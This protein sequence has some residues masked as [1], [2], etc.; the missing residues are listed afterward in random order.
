MN[1][2]GQH[3]FIVDDNAK[4]IQVTAQILKEHGGEISFAQDG[5]TA[6][7][8]LEKF[9]PD[10]ILLDIK[11]PE[12]S[13]FEVCRQIQGK[14]EIRDIPVIFLTALTEQEFIAQ[15]FEVG[16]VDYITKPINKLEVLAR[17]GNH[18]NLVRSRNEL[19]ELNE[20]LST[21][22]R[23]LSEKN[24][25]LHHLYQQV[26]KQYNDIQSSINYASGIINQLLP[27][28]DEMK[29][30]LKDCFVFFQPCHTI[31]GD[32]YWA[33]QVRDN[34]YFAVVDGTGHGV[35]GALI[36]LHGMVSLNELLVNIEDISTP[37]IVSQLGQKI[38]QSFG[39]L[40]SDENRYEID[41]G[42]GKL[43]T[44]EKKI[45]Y[46]GVNFPL[47]VCRS[48]ETEIFKPNRI[49]LNYNIKNNIPFKCYEIQLKTG[50]LVYL[51]TDGYIDQIGGK[52]NKKLKRRRFLR[53]ITEYHTKDMKEQKTAFK[54][55]IEE[56]KGN[57]IQTDDITL[58][59][60]KV[61]EKY[62]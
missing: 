31:G 61:P 6:L 25:T 24:E 37:E 40:N 30:A 33:T 23:D 11:M 8:Q 32:F 44:T 45:W 55:F 20:K 57:N 14:P 12:M 49:S 43:N 34:I 17:V 46:S 41:L 18:L 48:N 60:L 15:G 35:P 38:M 3:I 27:G 62:P 47:F 52:K 39:E 2:S 36:S 16:G 4:N 56:W 50:D 53:L 59:G 19:K 22:N 10:L 29:K 13:G 7:A 9:Q 5:K 51:T 21:V 26:N 58:L 42:V 1:I 28:E 54:N